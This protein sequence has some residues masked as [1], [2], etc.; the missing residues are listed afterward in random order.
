LAVARNSVLLLMVL[1]ENIQ[2]LNSRSERRSAFR[3][4][5]LRN[6]F[7]L[8]GTLGTQAIHIG[9]LYTPVLRRVLETGP[10]SFAHWTVLLVLALGLLA[11][12]ELHKAL[13]RR[14]S[15]RFSE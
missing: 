13:C 12:M 4:S 5:L 15:R 8:W 2:V 11:V 9:A 6:P 7:L 10:V 3:H 14:F 1:F